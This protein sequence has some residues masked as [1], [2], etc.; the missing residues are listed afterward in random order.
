MPV[1]ALS[2]GPGLVVTRELGDRRWSLS[3]AGC[4]SLVARAC[5]PKEIVVREGGLKSHF[6]PLSSDSHRT[7]N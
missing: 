3:L 2:E 7:M 1:T 6:T 5:G 4:S